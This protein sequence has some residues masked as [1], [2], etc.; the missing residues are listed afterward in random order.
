M[1]VDLSALSK[2]IKRM[3]QEAAA[4]AALEKR[5]L[6]RALEALRQ[7]ARDFEALAAKVEASRTYWPAARPLEPLDARYPAPKRLRIE[8][9]KVSGQAPRVLDEYVVIASD[10]SQIEPDRHGIALCY[11]INVGLALLRY[12]RNPGAMLRS[13]PSL[14]FGDD[15]LYLVS[16]NR[17][18]LIQGHLLA[19]KRSVAETQ[20]L[21]DLARELANFRPIICLQDGTLALQTLEGW[22]IEDQLRDEMTQQFLRGLDDLRSVGIPLASYISRPRSTEMGGLLRVWVC[23]HDVTI[24]TQHCRELIPGNDHPCA[25]LDGMLDRLIFQALPL[26]PGE[27]SALF[28]ASS[29]ISLER[30]LENKVHFFFLN[31]GS[32]V[33]RVE[34]PQWVARD[35]AALD[36]VHAVVLDQCRRGGG[37][38]RA[39]SE[40]HEKAVVSA[41]D[42]ET[43]WRLVESA[44]QGAGTSTAP[45]QKLKS[46]RLRSI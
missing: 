2:Q 7:G 40:A 35:G 43:F 29:R 8:I 24:C 39:L 41:A 34:I 37:Y 13:V 10:G 11:L 23:P 21:V 25:W 16:N 26:E 4:S 44:L 38:P 6:P 33:A 20:A 15:E 28:L 27:R 30:Y 12:G 31:T 19:V 5:H 17:R 45:S 18:I 42:R 22:G 3:G 14:H 36:T 46:K 32:E 1:T 9:E